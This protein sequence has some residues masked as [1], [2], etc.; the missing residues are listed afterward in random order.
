MDHDYSE[1]ESQ[2]PGGNLMARIEGLAQEQLDA[3]ARVEAIEL[4][5]A[6]AKAAAVLVSEKK[7]PELLEEAQLGK[8]KIVTPGGL[9]I[10]LSNVIRGSIPKGNE[11]EAHKWLEDNGNGG[12]IKRTVTID[13]NKDEEAWAAK[14]MRDCAQRKKT[15][16]LKL[17]RGVHTLTLRAFIKAALNEGTAIPLDVFGAF[18][19]RL[20]KVKVKV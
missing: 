13:F 16:N 9:V 17:V 14:F 8:S 15:L 7:L 4:Q 2:E 12:L 5:L 1:W 19:Q 10:T 11:E 18:R 6:E 3:E 20:T